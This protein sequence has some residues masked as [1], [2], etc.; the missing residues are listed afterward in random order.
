[1]TAMVVFG[2]GGAGG[3]K[4]AGGETQRRQER[5]AGLRPPPPPA[6][7]QVIC[8]SWPVGKLV[9]ALGVGKRDAGASWVGLRRANRSNRSG[10]AS[11]LVENKQWRRPEPGLGKKT[12]S[13]SCCAQKKRK[14]ERQLFLRSSREEMPCR[15][16]GRRQ[17]NRG[18]EVGRAAGRSGRRRRGGG[19]FNGNNRRSRVT[20]RTGD[21]VNERAYSTRCFLAGGRERGVEKDVVLCSVCPPIA[22]AEE[23]EEGDEVDRRIDPAASS[24]RRG[25]MHGRRRRGP[26]G[27]LR[28]GVH[29]RI[30]MLLLRLRFV[31]SDRCI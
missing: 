19:E 28:R 1:M 2:R 20:D 10:S 23:E 26:S 12:L 3:C 4:R 30:C 15:R 6:A 8:R 31:G 16:R 18:G 21:G 29:G 5:R 17:T 13:L 25:P 9:H 22:A 7:T 24:G 11:G 14:E 27:R